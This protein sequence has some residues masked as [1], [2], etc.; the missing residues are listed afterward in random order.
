[1]L[2]II[3]DLK[4]SNEQKETKSRK[5]NKHAKHVDPLISFKVALFYP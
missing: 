3:E 2:R 4:I 5:E 1:M